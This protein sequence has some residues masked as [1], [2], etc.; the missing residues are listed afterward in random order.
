MVVYQCDLFK[1]AGYGYGNNKYTMN[2]LQTLR[3]A[4][5]EP[6]FREYKNYCVVDDSSKFAAAVY[7]ETLRNEVS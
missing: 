2:D 6:I 1:D 3:N 7:N 5:K 4:E